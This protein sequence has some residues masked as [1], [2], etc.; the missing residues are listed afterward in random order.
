MTAVHVGVVTDSTSLL[1]AD[2]A[3]EHGVVVV[4]TLITIG[5][6][7]H[8][9]FEVDTETLVAALASKKSVSTSRPAPATFAKVYADLAEAGCTEIVS[10]HLSGSVS[11]TL[12]SA[13]LAAR[14]APV[15]VTVVDTLAVGP[16]IGFAALS[17]AE[18]VAGGASAAE[19][20]E[21]AMDRANAAKSIFYV[22]TLEYLRRGGRLGTFGALVGSA[23]SVKP[24]LEIIDG[25]V[26]PKEKVRTSARALDRLAEI[27]VESAGERPVEVCVA[28]LANP[29]PAL[30]LKERLSTDL[31]DQ[32]DGCEV[33]CWEIGAVLGAHAGPGVIAV[34][35]APR[36]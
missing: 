4:P 18:A 8:P 34:C 14:G 27:A 20:A 30:R 16:C 3:A 32:L 6:E 28:H 24:L 35:V 12:E 15:P 5:D 36:D 17:A 19:A 29:E 2:L 13:Q 10:V 23:L 22:D 26:V 33:V 11:G 1:P 7:S 31:A 25:R 9:E 21:V